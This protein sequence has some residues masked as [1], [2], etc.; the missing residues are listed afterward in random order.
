MSAMAA[1]LAPAILDQVWGWSGQ[2][3][4]NE[5]QGDRCGPRT[6]FPHE[7]FFESVFVFVLEFTM[8][9]TLLEIEVE[10][11]LYLHLLQPI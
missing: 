2:T 9:L 6:F 7:I 8:L 11:I 4:L 10:I 1:P 3:V 5:D